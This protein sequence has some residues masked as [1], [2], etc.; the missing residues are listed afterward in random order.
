MA[1]LETTDIKII[2]R[3]KTT[4]REVARQIFGEIEKHN[5][6]VFVN[7]GNGYLISL[8]KMNWYQALQDRF[9]KEV[10]ND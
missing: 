3:I 10:R 6:Q 5:L 1:R 2:D 7:E 9:P 8:E 4:R